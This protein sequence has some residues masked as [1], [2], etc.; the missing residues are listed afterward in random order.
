MET[1]KKRIVVMGGGTGTFTVLS[2]LK[3]YPLDLSAIVAM[4]DDGGSTGILRD[5][6]GVLPPGDVRQC[7]VA[8]SSSDKLMRDLINYRFANGHFQGHSFGNILLSALEKV[9][10]S[11][12]QAVEKAS[13]IL[14][15]HGKVIP[16][17]LDKVRLVAEFEDR[18]IIGEG[19]ISESN[20]HGLKRI[21]L[22]P[23]ARGNK[24]AIEAIGN[25][26]AIVIGPGNFYSSLIPNM[27]VFRIPQ[28]VKKSKAI[29][30]YVCNL[31]TRNGQT[32]DFTVKVF[33]EKIEKYLGCKLDY[34]IFN[35][36]IPDSSLLKKYS[37]EGE[38]I[39]AID[40]GLDKKKFIGADLISRKLPKISNQDMLKRTLIRH[41]PDKLAKIILELI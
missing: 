13:D 8:L 19:K 32:S 33:A 7:L 22:S 17:T 10:G 4:A 15:I 3:K 35:T 2:G 41:N 37:L 9:T 26:D 18:K 30:I 27:L 40:M 21:Y 25:A 6:L 16:A 20:L 29:K 34:V 28:A 24:K 36:K 14:R 11:F 12:D 5:E 38:K 31:M 23:K 1:K 39:T